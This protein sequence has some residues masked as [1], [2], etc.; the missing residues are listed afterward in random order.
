MTEMTAG[1]GL[2]GVK[3]MGAVGGMGEDV[4]PETIMK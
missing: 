3:S 1:T 2:W 4:L